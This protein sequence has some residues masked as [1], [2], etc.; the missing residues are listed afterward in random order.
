MNY[1]FITEEN[2]KAFQEM[3]PKT[4]WDTTDLEIGAIEND[5]PVGIAAVD[6]GEDPSLLWL[7]VSEDMRRQGIAEGLLDSISYVLRHN[8]YDYLRCNYTEDGKSGLSPLFTKT[9]FDVDPFES[10]IYAVKLSDV[11]E[12][13][14]AKPIPAVG[15]ERLMPLKDLTSKAWHAFQDEMRALRKQSEDDSV[16][17]LRMREEYDGD[18]SFLLVDDGKVVGCLLTIMDDESLLIDYMHILKPECKFGM[19]SLLQALWDTLG[20]DK[21][22]DLTI[23]MNAVNP[24][25]PEL[26]GKMVKTKPDSLGAAKEAIL[27]L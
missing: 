17:I 27:Y 6:A 13:L 9:G 18:H 5:R 2:K 7:Y 14:F 22:Q 25:V 21:T 3:M 4:C 16:P 8:G 1:T 24:V 20:R 19:M 23:V 10:E 12:Q 15:F 26:I 11:N